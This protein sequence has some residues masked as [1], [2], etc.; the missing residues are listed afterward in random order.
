MRIIL[1]IMSV[2]RFDSIDMDC[3]S[4]PLPHSTNIIMGNISHLVERYEEYSNAR[5]ECESED[6]ELVG[7]STLRCFNGRWVGRSPKCGIYYSKHRFIS[8][9]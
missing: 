2:L 1:I 8:F 6:Q 3:G 5:Y 9:H 4:P 7:D